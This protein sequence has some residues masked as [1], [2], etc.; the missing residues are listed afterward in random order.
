MVTPVVKEGCFV[1]LR[2][3]W[4]EPIVAEGSLHIA[5]PLCAAFLALARIYGDQWMIRMGPSR[6]R[7]MGLKLPLLFLSF[8][9][10]AALKCR[11][12]VIDSMR[13]FSIALYVRSIHRSNHARP[14][15]FM[16]ARNMGQ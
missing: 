15:L 8:E 9:A 7:E 11:V 12:V 5:A 13:Y 1:V 16:I 3:P 2:L 10:H 6:S 14:L 4:R